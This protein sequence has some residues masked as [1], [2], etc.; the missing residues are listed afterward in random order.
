V[1]KIFAVVM[2]KGGVGKTSIVMH[3]A[4]VVSGNG[5]V[6]IVDTDSQGNTSN[7]FGISPRGHKRTLWNVIN[8]DIEGKNAIIPVA[9]NIDL[10]PSNA[11]LNKLELAMWKDAKQFGNPFDIVKGIIS[12]IGHMY[13]YVFI[14]TPPSLSLLTENALGAADKVFIPFVPEQFSVQGLVAVV[15]RMG[16]YP[17]KIA[18]VIAN[19]VDKRTKLHMEMVRQ[20][21]DFCKSKNIHMFESV[22]PRTIEFGKASAIG[23]ASG[24]PIIQSIFSEI[25][26]EVICDVQYA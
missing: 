10:L 12:D 9:E 24:S 18:G 22:I 19:M 17:Y 11:D 3:L 7:A 13:N 2:N 21:R 15:E 6:L 5:K 1:G 23:K 26:K 14:D 8:G 20:A 16:E 25:V 4:H